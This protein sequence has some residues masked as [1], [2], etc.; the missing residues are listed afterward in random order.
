MK[1]FL[2]L[3]TVLLTTGAFAFGGIGI[4]KL[5]HHKSSGV[6]AIGVHIDTTGKKAD[7]KIDPCSAYSGTNLQDDTTFAGG[8]AGLAD[9]G[10]SQCRCPTGQKWNG[11]AC[12]SSEGA[13]CSS[14]TTNECGS[15]YY[16]QFS[17]ESCEEDPTE[18]VCQV[19]SYGEGATYTASNG[20]EYWFADVDV[21]WWTAQSICAEKNKILVPRDDFGLCDWEYCD[22]VSLCEELTNNLVN[23]DFVLTSTREGC[24]AWALWP[25]ENCMV[26][27]DWANL[28]DPDTNGILCR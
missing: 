8:Y 5:Q 20:Y 25:S 21:D 4:G 27:L 23:D 15:G 2:L 26:S 6:D 19:A 3:S 28:A 22:N 14:W 1:K 17:P 10:E 13:T 24:D 12:V 9:D 18:G 7:I 11:S 16:C